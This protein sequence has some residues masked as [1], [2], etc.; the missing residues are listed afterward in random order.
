MGG[1]ASTKGDVYSYGFLVLE[2]FIGRM[3]TNDRFK[4]D[5]N[6]HN[7][8]KMA[9]P[10]RLAQVVDPMLLPRGAVEMGATT[11]TMIAI[12][13]DEK[14]GNEIEVN[15]VNYVMD[16]WRI[17]TNMQKCILSILNI[18]ILCSLESPKERISMEE[19]IK[20]LVLI[21]NTFAGL[22]IHRGRPSS[23]QVN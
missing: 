17:G 23:A 11:S 4:N 14:N 3:P 1:E 15:E 18:G 19:V 21:K 10:K 2:M 9:L 16:S 22:G 6:L 7:F 12:E 20:E 5:L 8:V 13:E